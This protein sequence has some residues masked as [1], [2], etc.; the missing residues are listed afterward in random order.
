MHSFIAV[1]HSLSFSPTNVKR[2]YHALSQQNL[3]DMC[4]LGVYIPAIDRELTASRAAPH[5]CGAGQA[6]GALGAPEV[7]EYA[8]EII[9]RRHTI[10]PVA[11]HCIKSQGERESP[12]TLR[13]ACR[14]FRPC[15]SA[16]GAARIDRRCRPWR[17]R[18]PYRREG[19]ESLVDCGESVVDCGLGSS[20]ERV[21]RLAGGSAVNDGRDRG[22]G[23]NPRAKKPRE[24]A[25]GSGRDPPK[26]E[27]VSTASGLP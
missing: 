18:N 20:R 15:A 24:K 2:E 1:S 5:G 17:G 7:A 9:T 23:I 14:R 16:C 25:V 13:R 12:R 10:A 8:P 4:L 19:M 11:R 6:A 26:S 27:S 22:G 3:G 21:R